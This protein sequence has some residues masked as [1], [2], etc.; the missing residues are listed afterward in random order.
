MESKYLPALY[1]KVH[2]PPYFAG[3]KKG[4]CRLAST[5]HSTF[6]RAVLTVET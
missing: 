5:L 6:D 2:R 4:Q 3:R 1:S